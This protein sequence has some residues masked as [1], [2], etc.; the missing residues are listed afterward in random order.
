MNDVVLARQIRFLANVL[1]CSEEEVVRRGV[2]L[3]LQGLA[4][5]TNVPFERLE[6]G[7]W[8]REVQPLRFEKG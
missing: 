2:R 5:T 6:S 4:A 1:K 7:R 3:L 8:T